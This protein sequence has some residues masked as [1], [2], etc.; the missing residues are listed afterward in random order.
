M[1]EARLGSGVPVGHMKAVIAMKCQE[2]KNDPHMTLYLRPKTLF[3][4]SN[5][6][7]Y[8]GQLDFNALKGKE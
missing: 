8:Y 1:I 4:A 2:W 7:Q 6:E 5:F 3:I